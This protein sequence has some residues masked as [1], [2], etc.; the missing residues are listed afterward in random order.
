[1]KHPIDPIFEPFGSK[2]SI[3]SSGNSFDGAESRLQDSEGSGASATGSSIDA[4]PTTHVSNRFGATLVAVLEA[5]SMTQA[6]LAAEIDTSRAYVSML[7]R[8][9]RS[10]SPE[11]IDQISDRIGLSMTERTRLH[12]SAAEDRGFRLDLP[13]DF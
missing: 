1:M 13:D 9:T 3:R 10:V 5:R 7:A 6:A 2:L 8:G 4:I 12:R 11:R